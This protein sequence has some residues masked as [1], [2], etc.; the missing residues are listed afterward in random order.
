MAL[1]PKV[2]FEITL[3]DRVVDIVEEGYDLAVRIATLPSST[4]IS[5]R[6]S[7]ARLVLCASPQYLEQH[8]TPQHPDELSKHT[9]IAYSYLST[10]D[11]WQFVGPEGKISIQTRPCM[12]TNSGETC[13]AAALAHQGVILQPTFLVGQDIIE[14]RLVEL[15]PQYR[16]AEFGI[17]AVYPTRKHV[18]TKVRVLI[19][20]LIDCFRQP[21]RSW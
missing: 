21:P 12:H 14:G 3:V 6:L 16:G 4:L 18:P 11:E 13:R 17:F 1:H 8:G 5:R 15:L 19:D 20:F 9:I 7:S 2:T 10:K